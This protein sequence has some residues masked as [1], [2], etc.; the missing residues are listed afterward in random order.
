MEHWKILVILFSVSLATRQPMW[1]MCACHADVPIV[2]TWW[3]L[4]QRT[5]GGESH[6][7]ARVGVCHVGNLSASVSLPY[8]QTLDLSCNAFDPLDSWSF[9]LAVVCNGVIFIVKASLDYFPFKLP[10]VAGHC[11]AVWATTPAEGSFV[12]CSKARHPRLSSECW[13]RMAPA[14]LHERWSVASYLFL[15]SLPCLLCW[16]FRTRPCLLCILPHLLRPSWVFCTLLC[17][18]LCTLF[19]PLSLQCSRPLQKVLYLPWYCRKLMRAITT[20][21]TVM[22]LA[23]TK[24]CFTFMRFVS[25]LHE[26]SIHSIS[27]SFLL[28]DMMRGKAFLFLRCKYTQIRHANLLAATTTNYSHVHSSA[29]ARKGCRTFAWYC[30]W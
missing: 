15:L 16:L 20:A 6:S 22:S 21:P 14:Q 2:Y 28:R 11:L 25:P 9:W 17:R 24:M 19:L 10:P 5:C 13:P 7:C 3:V 23:S 27:T 29:H 1:D 4:I 30:I 8:N 12:C 26:R 18:L